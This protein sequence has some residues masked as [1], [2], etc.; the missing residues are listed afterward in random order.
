M[1][2]ADAC[3]RQSR[4][5]TC[6]NLCR[7]AHK[8]T[9]RHR[10]LLCNSESEHAT[11]WKIWTQETDRHRRLIKQLRIRARN[12]V[13]DYVCGDG[14]E[15]RKGMYYV[16]IRIHTYVRRFERQEGKV[17]Y[18]CVCM[19]I[20]IYIYIYICTRTYIKIQIKSREEVVLNV[21]ACTIHVHPWLYAGW[22]H[23]EVATCR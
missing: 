17:L 6:E 3:H 8:A 4:N 22:T 12:W 11:E 16:C 13:K 18:T 2:L 9:G 10:S 20:Y 23:A 15:W 19:H 7:N 5:V 21:C 14:Y 1:H